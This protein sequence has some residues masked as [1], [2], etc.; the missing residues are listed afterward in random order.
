MVSQ[1]DD[2]RRRESVVVVEARIP[3]EAANVEVGLVA[4]N[5]MLVG[6]KRA[7]SAQ[8]VVHGAGGRDH[9]ACAAPCRAI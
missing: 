4:G 2:L 5:P 3:E 1:N 9:C 8:R 6:T 7:A